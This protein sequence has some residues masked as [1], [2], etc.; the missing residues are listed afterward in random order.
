MGYWVSECSFAVLS[1]WHG[2]SAG[3]YLVLTAL[4]VVCGWLRI[5]YATR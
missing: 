3:D 1:W 5:R 4:V 2:A